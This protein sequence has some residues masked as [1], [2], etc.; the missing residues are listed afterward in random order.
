MHHYYPLIGKPMLMDR[1]ILD[2]H[3]ISLAEKNSTKWSKFETTDITDGPEYSN[4]SSNGKEAQKVT[5][6]GSQLT[7]SLLWIY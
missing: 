2:H 7:W 3:L 1:I 4:I 6:H 5:T